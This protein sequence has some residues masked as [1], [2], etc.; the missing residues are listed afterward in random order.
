MR[1]LGYSEKWP[2]FSHAFFTYVINMLLTV[3]NKG[4]P[5]EY[6]KICEN[7]NLDEALLAVLDMPKML[8][9]E[10]ELTF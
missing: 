7:M 1:Q 5:R 10:K 2:I 4:P 9:F 3:I 8:Q 6:V